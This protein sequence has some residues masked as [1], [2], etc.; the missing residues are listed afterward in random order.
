MVAKI[1]PVRVTRSDVDVPFSLPHRFFKARAIGQFRNQ[2]A[3]CQKTIGSHLNLKSII[4]HGDHKINHVT[5]YSIPCVL[6]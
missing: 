2:F 5:Y 4:D 1:R 6:Y 3:H